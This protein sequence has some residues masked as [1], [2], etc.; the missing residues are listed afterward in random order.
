V[1][2]ILKLW[3]SISDLSLL[4]RVPQRSAENHVP[5]DEYPPK[6]EVCLPVKYDFK[7]VKQPVGFLHCRY[8]VCE[9]LRTCEDHRVNREDV[10]HHR[11]MYLYFVSPFFHCL[12][13]SSL[14]HQYPNYRVK[15][16]Y[17]FTKDMQKSWSRQYY[18]RHLHVLTPWGLP[19]RWRILRQDRD[20]SEVFSTM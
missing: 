11:F 10:S 17:P 3:H 12:L 14:L 18:I 8:Y 4:N 13:N 7:C 6:Q 15:W 5:S 1:L 19:C 2:S 16:D 20:V 9:H